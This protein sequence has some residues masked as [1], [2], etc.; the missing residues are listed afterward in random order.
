MP[1]SSDQR[2][3]RP[4]EM[5]RRDSITRI[6]QKNRQMRQAW[7]R[8]QELLAQLG[9]HAGYGEML[10]AAGRNVSLAEKY[11]R[12]RGMAHRIPERELATICDSCLQ[13]WRA[14][15]ASFLVELSRLR[16]SRDRRRTLQTAL[17][18]RWSHQQLQRHIRQMIGPRREVVR[19]GRRRKV[20]RTDE[21][22]ILREIGRLARSWDRFHAELAEDADRGPGNV[23]LNA[24]TETVRRRYADAGKALLD[25]QKSIERRLRHLQ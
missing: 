17:I 24:L 23:G 20:D 11:R 14:W 16:T 15:G 21:V 13:H 2:Q 7:K 5:N 19:T 9:L 25:L 6:R 4:S 10:T 22:E 8:G 12:F 1:E 18:E 3:H